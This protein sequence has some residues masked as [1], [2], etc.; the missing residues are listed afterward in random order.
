[1]PSVSR[2]HLLQALSAAGFVIYRDDG[3]A[4]VLER[5]ARGVVVP[6][7]AELPPE[8]VYEVRRMAGLS[9]AQLEALLAR[10]AES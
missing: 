2:H 7:A 4:T 1:M 6:R 5:G 10:S 3:I 9:D 8:I